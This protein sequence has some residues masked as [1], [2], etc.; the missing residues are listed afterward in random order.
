MGKKKRRR[1]LAEK[2]GPN[3]Q[4][5]ID[6]Y[7]TIPSDGDLKNGHVLHI[8][9]ENGKSAPKTFH[10]ISNLVT[11]CNFQIHHIRKI[12]KKY[13]SLI[14][15]SKR[16]WN[17]FLKFCSERFRP[18]TQLGDSRPVDSRP[19]D[20]ESEKTHPPSSETVSPE[21]PEQCATPGPSCSSA[22]NRTSSQMVTPE[23]CATP[24]PSCSS[25]ADRT[26]SQ[27]VTPEQCATPGP[28]CSSAANRTSSP[29]QVPPTP[30]TPSSAHS[31]R[32]RNITP[33]KRKLKQRLEFISSQQKQQKEHYHE[34]VRN[35]KSGLGLK[36]KYHLVQ[37][38]KRKQNALRKKDRII[39]EL[40][41][42]TK[43]NDTTVLKAEMKN[44]KIKLCRLKTKNKKAKR[45]VE[46]PRVPMER[47][48]QLKNELKEKDETIS[49]LHSE[50]LQLEEM[51][52][53]LQSKE[54]RTM[55]DGKTYNVPMRMIVYNSIVHQVPT[56]NI[57]SLIQ[58]N[59]R[60]SGQELSKV[61]Q[62][63]TVE[64]MTRELDSIADLKTA[65]LAMKTNNLTI[66]FDA[67][68]QEG[69]HINCIHLNTETESEIVDI[70][71]LS[72]G[73]ADD[74]HEHITS[75]IDTLA[76]VYADFHHE[77]FQYC[78]STIINNISN[79]MSDRATVNQATVR[80]VNETWNKNLNQLNCHLHPLDTI[81]STCRSTL[82]SLETAKGSV[83][84]N[85]CIVANT[86]LQVNKLRY[87][88][89]KGDPKAFKTFL[90]DNLL[91]KGFIPR[92]RGNRI[93]V[94][95]HICGKLFSHYQLFQ[96]FFKSGTVACGGLVASLLKD[97]STKTAVAEL[98][99]LGL[100]GKLLTGP[101][102]QKF[103]TG[104]QSNL[105]HVDAIEVVRSIVDRLKQTAANPLTVLE[106][107]KDFFGTDLGTDDD[108]LQKLRRHPVDQDL[109]ETMMS[110]CLYAIT[111]VL[112]RQYK[113]YFTLDVTDKLREETCSARLHNIDSEELVGMYNAG[114]DRAKN[115]NVDF[116]V[117]RMRAKKNRVLPWLDDMF[118]EKRERVVLWSMGTSRRKRKVNQKKDDEM[119]KEMSKR[120]ANKRQK[121]SEKERK[122]VERKLKDVDINNIKTVFPDLSVE[123]QSGLVAI[124]NETAVGQNI[125]HTWYDKDTSDKTVWSG[126]IEKVNKRKQYRI[127]YWLEDETYDDD[128]EDYDIPM[129][130]L[131]ADLIFGDLI[132]S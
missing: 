97:F 98:Q 72:G 8:F 128:S 31:L 24:G 27:M 126:K 106:Q 26:S 37:E 85:D 68:T 61:P 79:T 66:G 93:H 89:G 46:N 114:K 117:A 131:A 84:G 78:R 123:V 121:R 41:K 58:S 28:S 59:A 20:G 35:F 38:I 81:A 83:F 16:D 3:H 71:E 112:E 65:E 17:T 104:V 51:I 14:K 52:Q 73:T 124:L 109:F 7:S 33:R 43:Q 53:E 95:F 101:W 132:L 42:K 25:A 110:S 115:A 50:N 36:N 74:Y 19:T 39:A 29:S 21:V 118:Q 102:M 54:T 127:A 2:P 10:V 80:K 1:P 15:N 77:N 99:V 45:M 5:L 130:S 111:G 70:H 56:E 91:P 32:D 40:K 75:S 30:N 48:L 4:H 103:Y 34:K 47:F 64:Q 116:I 86:V 129:H 82:K 88:D 96:D 12:S 60:R 100:I 69:A 57:P 44:E 122:E 18:L 22:A 105:S 125:C 11:T 6:V 94:L 119:R 107:T 90:Q 62:R 108:T 92:Y 49:A 113:R 13:S 120:M 9:C 55:K 63:T 87:K 67:T 23:Q 76:H